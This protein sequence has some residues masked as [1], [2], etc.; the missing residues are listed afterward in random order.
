M[1]RTNRRRVAAWLL[2]LPLGLL[3]LS[4][5]WLAMD[6]GMW[7]LCSIVI[8]EDGTHTG[9][10]TLLYWRHF[11]REIPIAT[12]YGA[13]T[14]GALR[15]YGPAD[16]G[17]R[18]LTRT[19]GFIGAALLVAAAW[20]GATT[21]AGSSIAAWDLLQ[22][23]VRDGEWRYG[24]HWR[25]H[26]LSSVVYGC[27][28]IAAAALLSRI[29]DGAFAV[30]VRVRMRWLAGIG[31]TIVGLSLLWQPTWEPVTSPRVIGHQTR[32]V[33]T[34][35]LITLP[36]SLAVWLMTSGVG[37][38][39]PRPIAASRMPREVRAALVAGAF[40]ALALGVATL[41][42]QAAERT[43]P[44]VRLSSLV[45][46]HAVEH[47]LDYAFIIAVMLAWGHQRT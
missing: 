28:A 12:L 36:L 47:T 3:G 29:L 30:R 16:T 45:A 34:H 20:F 42:T 26:L 11:L 17:A 37:Q 33:V 32:E 43:W 7:N 23:Y 10:T 38:R 5:A 39:G 31:A 40:L 44:T 14:I 9:C 35:V 21:E 1:I 41:L 22:A 27:A 25:A 15:V 19:V 18:S 24:S 46:A 8:H 13:V 2:A 6:H 4:Y